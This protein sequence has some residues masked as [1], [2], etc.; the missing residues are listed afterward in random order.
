MVAPELT[1]PCFTMCI[2]LSLPLF[3]SAQSW[4]IAWHPCPPFPLTYPKIVSAKVM[5]VMVASRANLQSH[6]PFTVPT[7][8]AWHSARSFS[9]IIFFIS[10]LRRPQFHLS[11]HQ[12]P[13]P[14]RSTSGFRLTGSLYTIPVPTKVWP[15]RRQQQPALWHHSRLLSHNIQVILTLAGFWKAPAYAI[16]TPGLCKVVPS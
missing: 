1:F 8:T 6:P 4:Y 14:G 15:D 12:P 9:L 5:K 11:T 2:T 13:D 7:V 10:S 3:L 16:D